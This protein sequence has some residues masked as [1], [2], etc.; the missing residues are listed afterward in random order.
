VQTT[1]TEG[2]ETK[3]E[4]GVAYWYANDVAVQEK[5]HPHQKP[6]PEGEWYGWALKAVDGE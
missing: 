6:G 2:A 5:A 1:H 4:E 3:I